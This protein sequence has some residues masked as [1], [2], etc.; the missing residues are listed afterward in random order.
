V[1]E[2]RFLGDRLERVSDAERRWETQL[3]P[4]VLNVLVLDPEDLSISGLWRY[5]SFLRQQGSSSGEYELAFWNKV[6]QPLAIVSLLL[7]AASI[8][9]GPLRQATMGLR[10]FIGVLIGIVFRISQDM[11]GPASLVFGFAPI[12]ASLA[13]ILVSL[14]AGAV[15]LRRRV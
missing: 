10:V 2:T 1:R 12:I 4:E 6:L 15:L 9:F 11:L 13:P 8:V 3:S 7:V 14:V 5:A